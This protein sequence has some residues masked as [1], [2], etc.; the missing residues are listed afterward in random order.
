[1]I[2]YCQLGSYKKLYLNQNTQH[3]SLPKI[4]LKMSSAKLRPCC[5]GLILLSVV[6]IWTRLP[7]AMNARICTILSFC[8][9]IVFHIA[10]RIIIYIPYWQQAHTETHAGSLSW[11]NPINSKPRRMTTCWHHDAVMAWKRFLYYWLF[12]WRINLWFPFT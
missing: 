4:N 12:V 11:N 10:I 1:M 7:Q 2:A 6:Y 3:F 9:W 8:A 5:F